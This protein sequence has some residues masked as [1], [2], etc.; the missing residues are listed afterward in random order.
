MKWNKS[1][2]ELESKLELAKE[3]ICEFEDKFIV[4]TQSE[5]Q[6]NIEKQLSASV[7]YDIIRSS[8]YT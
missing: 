5:K 3:G 7:T 4:I 1:L 6:K 2:E 8:Q